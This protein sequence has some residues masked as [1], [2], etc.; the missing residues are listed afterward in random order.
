MSGRSAHVRRTSVRGPYGKPR[1][2]VILRLVEGPDEGWGEASPLAGYSPD[3]L[4]DAERDLRVWAVEWEAGANDRGSV[5]F[6]PSARCAID[7]ALLDRES[8][9]RSVP[10]RA[11]LAE[12]LPSIR[13]VEA[14]PVCALVALPGVDRPG[15]G[16]AVD[17]VI[18]EVDRRVDEGYLAVKFKVDSEGFENQL[19]CLARVRAA[20]PGLLIRLDANG[21]WSAEE[22]RSRLTTLADLVS[23]ALVEQ[24]VGPVELLT[25]GAAPVAI[26]ADESLRLPGALRAIVNRAA[27]QAIVLKPMILGGLSECVAL[28]TEAHASG[29]EAIVSHAFGGP[30]S[31]AAACELA[32]AIAA[33]TPGDTVSIPGLAGHRAVSQMD[34]SRIV[35][36]PVLGHGAAGP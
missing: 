17:D 28:A 10:L 21:C 29:M 26:A 23:P 2:A 31:H 27:C 15:V 36:A 19:T 5:D 16:P 33:N 6:A 11:R 13:T 22:A 12:T 25:F 4:D 14:V 32:L 34:G 20:H 8:R 7:T 3:T 35:A 30:I 24:P 9:A 1:D 18:S